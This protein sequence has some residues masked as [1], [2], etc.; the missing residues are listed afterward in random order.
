[1]YEGNNKH[2]DGFEIGLEFQ[3][4]I[5]TQLLRD[6]GIVIQP[7]SSKKFQ[8]TVGESL[9]GYEIKYDARSTGDCT[10]G[11]C[12]ATNNV[13]IEVYEKSNEIMI[14]GFLLES[15]GKTILFI[16]LLAI[17]ICVG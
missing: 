17:T 5:I 10:Y 11:Y 6:Y 16:I 15:Y 8:F 2:K 9:Q 4:F 7:Y 13:A 1:M 14:N 3:D 12:E